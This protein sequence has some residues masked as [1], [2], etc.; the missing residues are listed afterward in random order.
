M[1]IQYQISARTD[2]DFALLQVSGQLELEER[3]DFLDILDELLATDPAKLVIDLSGMERM[4][5]VYIGTLIDFAARATE[6]EKSVAAMLPKL[7]ADRCRLVGMEKAV[8][9]IETPRR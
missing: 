4:C 1:G 5:S 6:K 7:A 3:G 9:I 2:Q 8:Q